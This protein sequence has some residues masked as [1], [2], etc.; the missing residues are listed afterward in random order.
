MA[1]PDQLKPTLED[2]VRPFRALDSLELV[3]FGDWAHSSSSL[4]GKPDKSLGSSSCE[5]RTDSSLGDRHNLICSWLEE[6][7]MGWDGQRAWEWRN[8]GFFALIIYLPGLCAPDGPLQPAQG[9]TSK[10]KSPARQ[11]RVLKTAL[12]LRPRR[13]L[14]SESGQKPYTNAEKTEFKSKNKK[15][16]IKHTGNV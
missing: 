12:R 3:R 5:V 9:E 6:R 16:Q 2:G 1:R 10:G 7:L 8:G 4:T 15:K 13:A 14:S 11:Y